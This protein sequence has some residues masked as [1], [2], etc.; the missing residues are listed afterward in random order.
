MQRQFASS[1]FVIFCLLAALPARA[2][3]PSRSRITQ[4]ISESRMQTLTGNMHPMARAEFDQGAAPAD[5]PMERMQL[6]LTRSAEQET[7]L[8]ALLAAQQD[9][10]S[11]QYHQWLT[12]EQFGQRFG[13]SDEDVQKIT[14]WLEG[15][16]FHVDQVANGRNV[17]EFT[18]A[19]GAVEATFH[20][21]IRKYV[22]NGENHWANSND[23]QIPAALAGIV[24]GVATLHN[25]QKK[26]RAIRSN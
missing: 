11:P 19:A 9:S 7:D 24:A 5:L 16:G 12:P 14:G 23:P 8:Q 13:V 25:F 17:I 6:V 3:G 2:Q 22:V 26:P 20:T 21:H 4:A 10:S 1:F 18:G 15:N